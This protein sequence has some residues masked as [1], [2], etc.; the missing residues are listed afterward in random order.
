LCGGTRAL[1]KFVD[2]HRCR[3]HV[4]WIFEFQSRGPSQ[5]FEVA[6]SFAPPCV[7]LTFSVSNHKSQRSTQNPI[8]TVLAHFFDRYVAGLFI[9]FEC[10]SFRIPHWVGEVQLRTPTRHTGRQIMS[11]GDR[12]VKKKTLPRL[13]RLLASR[14]FASC[15]LLSFV[16]H[17]RRRPCCGLRYLLNRG[18]Y[19]TSE[20]SKFDFTVRPMNCSD[21]YLPKALIF[22]EKSPGSVGHGRPSN[23]AA[24][25]S[26]RVALTREKRLTVD[27]R[28]VYASFPSFALS[29]RVCRC[30]DTQNPN[31]PHPACSPRQLPRLTTVKVRSS[32]SL[33]LLVR[34]VVPFRFRFRS[35][36]IGLGGFAAVDGRAEG[37][38]HR[39]IG[40]S[41]D[42]LSLTS[43]LYSPTPSA[44]S[45]LQWTH[46]DLA[47]RG[48]MNR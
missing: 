32:S 6:K 10:L 9:V 3:W 8:V 5:S 37:R 7:A 36:L 29:V 18:P 39:L 35:Q 13:R 26:R 45:M 15:C 4:S 44:Y 34:F 30:I 16:R 23:S 11:G 14:R 17:P 27:V 21:R 24:A 22:R 48:H 12:I 25:A 41:N 42:S 46:L 33:R 20:G 40:D 28:T 47:K 38:L 1:S 2:H 43:P 19:E 31:Q